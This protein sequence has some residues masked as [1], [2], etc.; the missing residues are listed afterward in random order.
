MLII[1]D[2]TAKEDAQS[3]ATAAELASFAA[4]RG[5]TIPAVEAE[6]EALLLSAIDYMESLSYVGIRYTRD[7]GLSWPRV[8]AIVDGF[9]VAHNELPRRLKQ[10]QL[11]L[12][13][14]AITVDLMANVLPSTERVVIEEA[15]EGAVSVKYAPPASPQASLSTVGV[16][17]DGS[18]LTRARSLLRPLLANTG[19]V[20]V[21]RG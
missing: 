19:Q 7:Q 15:V 11:Q 6:Q 4:A 13:V 9:Y 10:A 16:A 20:R 5:I 21:M 12:A 18:Q 8:N 2:G 1:E 17:P 14:D 3:Y